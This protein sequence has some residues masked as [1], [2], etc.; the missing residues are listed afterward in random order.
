MIGNNG[1]KKINMIFWDLLNFIVRIIVN[2]SNLFNHTF[3]EVETISEN[4]L[5]SIVSS[6]TRISANLSRR[7]RLLEIIL[8]KQ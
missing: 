8:R 2:I 7:L 6:L 3:N 5:L 4:L 1:T